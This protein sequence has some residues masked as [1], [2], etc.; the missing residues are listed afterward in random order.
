MSVKK[1]LKLVG[2]YVF[3]WIGFSTEPRLIEVGTPTPEDPVFLTCNF[4]LTVKRV[5]KAM[6]GMDCYLL[7]AP[8]NGINV[9]CGACGDEFDT[10]SVLSILKTSGIEERVS[11]R[12]LILPQLSAPGIDPQVIKEKTGWNAEF[13][14]VRAKDIPT[15]VKNGFEKTPKQREVNFPIFKRIEM[16]NLYFLSLLVLL[17]P[18][19]WILSLFL[20]FLTLLL[21][22]SSVLISIGVIHGS[23]IVLPS[24]SSRPGKWKVLIYEFIIIGLILSFNFL[25]W[26]NFLCLFWNIIL[27]LVLSLLMM[28]DLHGLTPIYKSELGERKWK[29]GE[30]KMSFLFDEFDLQAYGDIVIQ[31]EKCIGCKACINVCPRL[32]FKLNDEDKKADLLYPNKC[33]NCHACVNR[34]LADCLKIR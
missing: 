26:F 10:N 8:S 11:H 21:Y 9:W 3:R 28:E 15:F 25:I 12:N 6:D 20:P 13:G 32:V 17:S 4:N 22:F 1:G 14:P 31:R 7:V 18:V 27:S 2:A 29:K 24:I 19:Y 33:I 30:T 23:I 16:G 34:C 5:L